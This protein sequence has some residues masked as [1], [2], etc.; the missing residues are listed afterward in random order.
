MNRILQNIGL[1]VILTATAALASPLNAV[2]SQG[3]LSYSAL[4]ENLGGGLLQITV[5]NTSVTAPVDES[6]VIGALFFSLNGDPLLTPI[7]LSLG[8][9]SIVVNGSGDPSPNWIY[10]AG[11]SGPGGAS[12]VLSAAGYGLVG[13]RGNFCS[14]VDCGALLQGIDWGLVDGGYIAGTGNGSIAGRVMIQ[15][16]AV[17]VLSGIPI[18]F[19]PS[20]SIHNVSAQYSASLDG[21]NVPDPPGVPE[22][23]SCLLLG[24]GLI[25]LGTIKK[26]RQSKK[27]IGKTVSA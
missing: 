13:S 15:E 20:T 21:A 19:D 10:A 23:A 25:L 6:N 3:S 11:V 18:E 24:G 17:F 27:E 4:F 26:A 1:L 12:Q 2:G 5:T 7:S 16:T 8:S 9:G 22:P 14:G